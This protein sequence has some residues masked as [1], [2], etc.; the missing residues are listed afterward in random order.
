[1]DREDAAGARRRARAHAC[2]HTHTRTRPSAD[3]W[4]EKMREVHAGTRVHACAHTH[5]HTHTHNETSNAAIKRTKF[6][7][8]QQHFG[9]YYTK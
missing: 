1:M 5:T 8:V 2:T 6:C 9:E 3:E 4:I 7:R